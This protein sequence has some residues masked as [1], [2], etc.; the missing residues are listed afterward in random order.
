MSS[1]RELAKNPYLLSALM[2]VFDQTPEGYLPRNNGRLF[3]SLVKALG[4]RESLRSTT[5]WVPFAEKFEVIE[6]SLSQLAFEMIDKDTGTE[7]SLEFALAVASREILEAAF[8][9]NY[10]DFLDNR[11]RFYHQLLQEYFAAA[12]L[13]RVDAV[14]IY[15]RDGKTEEVR[16]PKTLTIINAPKWNETFVSLA[17]ITG[18][19]D[20][21][22]SEFKNV[23]LLLAARSTLDTN[24]AD[25]TREE[26]VNELL[27]Y[28]TEWEQG[29][30]VRYNNTIAEMLSI[31]SEQAP[32][33]LIKKL[34]DKDSHV[35]AVCAT[36]LG[37][38]GDSKAIPALIP[39]LTQN[40]KEVDNAYWQLTGFVSYQTIE[41]VSSVAIWVLQKIGTLEALQAIETWKSQKA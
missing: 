41:T 27:Q 33:L 39:V 8:S 2:V 32:E 3:Q 21:H 40:S 5:G 19:I 6:K 7:V 10:L 11:V 13:R 23:N 22:I 28:A 18:K 12:H 38:I 37:L 25:Q 26:I 35:R 17:G 31:V 34:G 9:A 16:G 36:A 1:L 20:R 24:I 30:D 29:G 15:R 4:K 14:A